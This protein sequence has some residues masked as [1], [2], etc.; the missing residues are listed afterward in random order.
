MA[1]S[2]EDHHGADY[3]KDIPEQHIDQGP[4][5]HTIVRFGGTKQIGDQVAWQKEQFQSELHVSP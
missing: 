5:H 1:L 4:D 2:Q 3:D